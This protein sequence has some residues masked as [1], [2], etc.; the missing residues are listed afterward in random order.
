M[1]GVSALIGYSVGRDFAERILRERNQNF[2]SQVESL[3]H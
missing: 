2:A 3:A 1:D